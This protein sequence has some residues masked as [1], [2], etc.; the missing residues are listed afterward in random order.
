[1]PAADTFGL[2]AISLTTGTAGGPAASN[3]CLI[4]QDFVQQPGAPDA[5]APTTETPPDIQDH[6]LNHLESIA[7][8]SLPDKEHI[9]GVESNLRRS[10][11]NTEAMMDH[12]M[13]LPPAVFD[14]AHPWHPP[15]TQAQE[16]ELEDE[17]PWDDVYRDVKLPRLPE[18]SKDPILREWKAQ[19]VDE[20]DESQIDPS[21]SSSSSE[22]YPDI[23]HALRAAA[24]RGSES[25]VRKLLGRGADVNAWDDQ[26][27]TALTAASYA[28]H[29]SIV[30]LLLENGAAINVQAPITQESRI[31]ALLVDGIRQNALEAAAMRG[32][33]QIVKRLI[34]SGA[35]VNATIIN[36][37]GQKQ[38]A[39]LAAVL[40]GH[41]DVVDQLI[42]AGADINSTAM[43]DGGKTILQIATE[44][45]HLAIVNRLVASGAETIV[46]DGVTGDNN[47]ESHI[48][49][50]CYREAERSDSVALALEVF[51][52]S[53]PDSFYGY[54]LSALAEDIRSSSRL[55]K[56]L[57]DRAQ[58][59]ASLVPTVQRYLMV[60]LPCLCRTLRD[61]MSCI[62]DKT[63]T[64]KNR[65]QALRLNM[66]NI[67][68]LSIETRF[69]LYNQFLALL[70][71]LLSRHVA[72]P[73]HSA[74]RLTTNGT[75]ARPSQ[76]D[77]NMLEAVQKE[78]LKLREAIDIRRC[79]TMRD[80]Y[81]L[82]SELLLML[83]HSSAPK[84]GS[85]AGNCRVKHTCAVI[86]SRRS[87]APCYA[88]HEARN[89]LRILNIIMA[90]FIGLR[91]SSPCHCLQEHL[92]SISGTPSLSLMFYPAGSHHA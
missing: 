32:H 33:D 21:D 34:E 3:Q 88:Y 75:P 89:S 25:K 64:K 7:L 23:S 15:S 20:E 24:L 41:I 10:S 35:D 16:S 12:D 9:D 27:G 26:Y 62:E 45:G 38:N 67:E 44:G 86:G 6:L 61:I 55:L 84:P 43:S 48:F 87:K 81:A 73:I 90:S 47:T 76:S 82:P 51:L 4:C 60:L 42:A 63:L 56:E 70:L 59:H 28:G 18:P 54:N 29:D 78:I 52:N 57:G 74:A 30:K 2:L 17:V 37:G 68:G 39:L 80:T 31:E 11:D 65:Y 22:E 71:Q 58:V 5:D 8:L 40:G 66:L 50:G 36:S 53:L 83:G 91:R 46:E 69:T 19:E 77:L 49:I 1:M 72:P 14:D 85:S 13:D 79:N 92:W